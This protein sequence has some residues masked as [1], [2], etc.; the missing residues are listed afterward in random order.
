MCIV[1]KQ[2]FLSPCT[3][4]RVSA[5][6]FLFQLSHEASALREYLLCAEMSLLNLQLAHE[7]VTMQQ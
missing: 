6:T 7:I 4:P 5:Q 3:S 2:L 1:I